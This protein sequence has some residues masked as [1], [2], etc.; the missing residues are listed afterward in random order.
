ME[1]YFKLKERGTDIRTEFTAGLTTFLTMAYILA[2]NPI[3]LSETG[4]PKDALFTAT[5]LSAGLTTILM[6]VF[7][8]LPFAL[9]SGMGL[10]AYFASLVLSGPLKDVPNG[11]QIALTCVLFDGIIFLIISSLKIRTAIVNA[12][13]VNIKRAISVG[14]GLFIA[15][16]GFINAGV[17]KIVD[18]SLTAGDFTNPQTLLFVFGLVVTGIMMYKKIKGALLLGILVTSIVGWIYAGVIGVDVAATYGIFEPA[19][20][21]LLSVPPSVAPI[22][23]KFDFARTLRVSMVPVIFAFFFVDMFD[24]IG[25]FIGCAQKAKLTDENGNMDPKDT[26]RGL[27]TDA[28]G[29]IFGAFMGT[30]TVTTYIESSAGIA[31]GGRTGLTSV[32]TGLFFV[33]ALFMSNIFTSIPSAATAPALVIVGLLMISVI[34]DIDISED[35][36]E[37]IPAF[38]AITTMP[39]TSSISEG[40]VL[41]IVSY[42]LLKLFTGKAKQI[43]LTMYVLAGIFIIYLI[44]R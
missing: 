10:N 43:S 1:R 38:L 44:F 32:V 42:V 7:A 35:W 19:W 11:W 3:I 22:A 33:M 17:V 21:N 9:A 30:S 31:E 28:I 40:I 29:T 26:T 36:T 39:F 8:N 25:T 18:N 37:A 2:V 27:L 23:F 34:K 16:I 6:G 4:M 20:R 15:S 41:G 14:I 12:I 13:P 5:A 24:T